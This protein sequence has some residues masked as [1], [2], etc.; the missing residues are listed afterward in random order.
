MNYQK[1]RGTQDILPKDINK[2]H[3]IEQAIREITKIYGF[4]EIRTPIFE[5]TEVFKRENDSSDMVNKEMYSFVMGDTSLT[6]RPEQTASVARSYVENKLYGLDLPLKLY[7]VGPQFRHERP[8]K[9]R[10]RQFHQ[11]GVEVFGDKSPYLDVECIVL[12]YH[13]LQKLGIKNIKVKL[14]TLGD[15]ISRDNYREK[16][17]SHFSQD[18]NN[19][20]GDCQ[21]RLNQNPLRVLDCKADVNN[22]LMKN[23][24]EILDYLNDESQQFFESVKQGLTLLGIPYEVDAKLVRG[25]DYYCHTVFEIVS[26]D[27]SLGSQSTI[28]GGGRYE[29]LVEHFGGPQT[30]AVGFAMGLERVLLACE[31]D[32]AINSI[33][34]YVLCLDATLQDKAFK[35][36][37]DLRNNGIITQGDYFSRSFKA[38]FRSVDKLNAKFAVIVGKRDDENNQVVIKDITL[39]QQDTVN[40]E[41]IVS[42]LKNKMKGE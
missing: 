18:I 21:R 5:H 31:L 30:D 1:P 41:N 24:P 9:G 12:G 17:V 34:A 29:K 10:Q 20:C 40:Y 4:E 7:Y 3:R 14:N 15:K 11:F 13:L 6:L 37:Q 38:Q 32:H 39:Q 16:L 27:D 8:Q 23:A 33:D 42:Y 36:V 35:L 22:T 26:T 28:F 19:F 25:L 2:W